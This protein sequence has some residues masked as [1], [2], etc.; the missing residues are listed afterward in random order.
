M[1][2]EKAE[3]K[4]G[5]MVDEKKEEEG[6]NRAKAGTKLGRKKN[7][8]IPKTKQMATP[9]VAGRRMRSM[10]RLT[11]TKEQRWRLEASRDRGTF[12]EDLDDLIA[13]TGLNRESVERW[14]QENSPR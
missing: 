1:V 12:F 3:E 5:E 14:H 10:D 9:E 8:E 4:K 13:K 2:E 7:A 6:K 11:I